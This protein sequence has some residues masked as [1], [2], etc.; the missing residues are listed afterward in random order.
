MFFLCYFYSWS[1]L[2][3]LFFGWLG[4]FW[5]VNNIINLFFKRF[6]FLSAEIKLNPEW[7]VGGGENGKEMDIQ[8]NRNHREQ[9]TI[10]KTFKE[11]PLNPKEPW[12][13]EMDYD[14]SLTPVIPTEQPPEVDG[15][16]TQASHSREVDNAAET[17]IVPSQGV[18]S[19]V[20]L[21]PQTNNAS[22]TTE[23]DLELLAV[24]LK[25]PEL[26]F[27]LTSGQGGNLSSEDTVKL[28]DMIKA[29]GAGF[30]G[31]LNGLASKM[32]EKVEVS[33]PSPTPSSN[34]GTVRY[35]GSFCNFSQTLY[36]VAVF[37]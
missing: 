16:E 9:E 20:S 1:L 26:V 22:S 33:L 28:L 12:D 8:K 27:A 15:T 29:G 25:N 2:V 14:D 32:E 10:Y 34:P 13:I 7:R 19:A 21:A 30:A 6:P 36:T 23:P 17:L 5:S 11:I 18:N 4:T 35:L 37:H 24:L 3:V 31:N